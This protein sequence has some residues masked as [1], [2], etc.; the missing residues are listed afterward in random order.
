VILVNKKLFYKKQ[1]QKPLLP[2][3]QKILHCTGLNSL[4][5][6]QIMKKIIVIVPVFMIF[7]GYT[8]SKSPTK[9][10]PV[11][12]SKLSMGTSKPQDVKEFFGTPKETIITQD[13]ET[14]HYESEKATFLARF[15]NDK[16]LSQFLYTEHNPESPI[17]F[18][19]LTIRKTR[20]SQTKEAIKGLLG[21]PTE[22]ML[23]NIDEAWY[24]EQGDKSLSLR[25]KNDESLSQFTYM[26]FN[27][28]API[29][30]SA[31]ID[32]LKKESTTVDDVYK[33]LGK[34]SVKRIN[35]DSETW[36]YES[37]RTSLVIHFD[38]N[39]ILSDFL[40]NENGK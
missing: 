27:K 5:K 18:N 9:I 36:T 15:G 6:I 7:S 28:V 3:S 8:Q 19:D 31:Q 13:F 1:G 22:V 11:L 21:S 4:L 29:I 10:D 30:E 20:N 14:L 32:F 34:P 26:E 25:F 23:N 12:V 16:K 37:T 24:Y 17:Q 2:K 39:S 33:S 38:K 35:K 40:Y